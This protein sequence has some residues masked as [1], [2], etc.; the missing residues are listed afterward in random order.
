MAL[1]DKVIKL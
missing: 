1:N